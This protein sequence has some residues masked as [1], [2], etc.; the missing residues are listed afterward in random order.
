MKRVRVS[1]TKYDRYV[2][3]IYFSNNM[4][5]IGDFESTEIGLHLSN[6]AFWGVRSKRSELWIQVHATLFCVTLGKLLDL[7]RPCLFFLSSVNVR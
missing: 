5:I 3:R 1:C 2:L 7:S 6:R 4:E